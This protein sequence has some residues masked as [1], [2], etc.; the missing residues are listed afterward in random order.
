MMISLRLGVPLGLTDELGLRLALGEIEGD[1]EAL[2]DGERDCDADGLNDGDGLT[3]DE[4]LIDGETED[5]GLKLADGDGEGEP[6]FATSI[7]AHT[8]TA[9]VAPVSEKV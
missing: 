3:L 8:S 7:S 5:D 2:D 1:T 4:G 9:F 6:M